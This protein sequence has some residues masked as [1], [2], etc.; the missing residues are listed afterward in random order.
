MV[1][2]K[3]TTRREEPMRNTL[4][5]LA[6]RLGVVVA[7]CNYAQRRVTELKVSPERYLTQPS[8]APDTYREFLMR[9]GGLLIHEPSAARRSAGSAL[10]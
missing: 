3:T 10:R 5:T 4:R 2:A 9:T 8:R 1:R 7:E 6:R